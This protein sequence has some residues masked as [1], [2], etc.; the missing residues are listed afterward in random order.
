[1]DTEFNM[2]KIS[3]FRP[4]QSKGVTASNTSEAHVDHKTVRINGGRQLCFP[5]NLDVVKYLLLASSLMLLY[6]WFS[7]VIFIFIFLSCVILCRVTF[8]IQ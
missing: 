6:H 4:F 2:K 1:M 7:I 8:V 3:V 5:L